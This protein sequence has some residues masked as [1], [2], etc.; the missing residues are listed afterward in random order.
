MLVQHLEV[1]KIT[2]KLLFLSNWKQSYISNLYVCGADHT[3]EIRPP[4]ISSGVLKEMF[5][6]STQVAAYRLLLICS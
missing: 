4:Q 3:F 5:T 2:N 1:P 6:Y